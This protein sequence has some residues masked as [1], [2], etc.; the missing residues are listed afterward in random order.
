V[1]KDKE[2]REEV[3]KT[4]E[5]KSTSIKV[6]PELWEEAKIAAIKRKENLYDLVER[7]LKKELA[8]VKNDK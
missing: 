7:A 5:R 3:E 2:E 8:V 6:D 1:S 4:I